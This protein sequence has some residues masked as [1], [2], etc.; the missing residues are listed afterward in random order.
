MNRI[1]GHFSSLLRKSGEI[2]VPTTLTNAR[3]RT[4]QAKEMAKRAELLRE[5]NVEPI[6][7]RLDGVVR[8]W[9]GVK[10]HGPDG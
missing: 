1:R 4:G 5:L 2:W 3:K 9:N 8:R 6:A 10:N 7:R